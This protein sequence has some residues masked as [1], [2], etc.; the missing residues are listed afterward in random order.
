M[1]RPR[2]SAMSLTVWSECKE[3]RL[4]NRT[5]PTA[6]RSSM[7]SSAKCPGW[8][9]SGGAIGTVQLFGWTFCKNF[10]RRIAFR[11]W[12]LRIRIGSLGPGLAH[13]VTQ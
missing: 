7:R 1:R 6:L 9:T 5:S 10:V 3:A 12:Q 8:N 11:L 2:P 4:A 13:E